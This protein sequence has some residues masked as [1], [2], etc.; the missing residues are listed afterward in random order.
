MKILVLGNSQVGAL[1]EAVL[2][3]LPEGRTGAAR[4]QGH[5]I[6]FYAQFGGA[7]PDLYVRGGR[8]VA[9][10]L[11]PGSFTT[12]P[13]AR[14]DGLSLADYDAVVISAVGL[15]RDRSDPRH[16]LTTTD[17]ADLALAP[18]PQ[19]V[20]RALFAKM[21][22]FETVDAPQWRTLQALRTIYS[23]PLL[24]QSWPLPVPAVQ[25]RDDFATG[26]RYGE[27]TGRFLSFYFAAMQGAV[28]A[29]AATL[30]PPAQILPLP[31][32]AWL[33]TGFTPAAYGSR[34]PWHMNAAYG[35]LVLD[36]IAVAVAGDAAQR[37]GGSR[38]ASR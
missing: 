8:L 1:R 30:D 33:A 32:P 24:F 14:D 17:V 23:G 2:P 5:D 37:L 28:E 20:S 22:A 10:R 16:L 21:V 35:A 26:R 6:T 3:V 25:G 19:S 27:N 18:G 31:D 4:W 9:P 38:S 36:Q 12:I 29:N 11:G 7:A 13:G 15:R 34:D